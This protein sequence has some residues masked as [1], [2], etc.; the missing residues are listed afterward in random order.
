VEVRIG[1]SRT[2]RECRTEVRGIQ[3]DRWP[4]EVAVPADTQSLLASPELGAPILQMGDVI[5]EDELR[6]LARD[7]GAIPPMQMQAQA[8][9]PSGIWGS[10]IRNSRYNR[11]EAFS[12]GLNG[13]FR[14]GHY[15]VDGLARIGVADLE[16]NVELGISRR[17]RSYAVRL[18]GY[19]R[20]EAANPDTRPFGVI[21]SLSALLAQRDDGEYFRTMGGELTM[22]P[23]AGNAWKVR[24]F[25]EQQRPAEVE[26]QASLPHLFDEDQVFRPNIVADTADQGGMA[27]DL[28]LNRPLG[29]TGSIGADVQ[30]VG[31]AGTFDFWKGA[32]TLRAN[33]AAGPLAVALEGA[34]GT[35]TGGLPVQSLFYVGGPG[36]LRGYDGGAMTGESYWRGRA[37]LGTREPSVRFVVFSDVAW[38]GDRTSFTTGKPFLGVGGGVAFLDGLFRLDLARAMRGPTGWR[39]DFYV[40]GLF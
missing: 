18:G 38:A 27:L 22:A 14:S 29:G 6:E 30:T 13:V 35:S 4:V 34:A 11:V 12:T 40:D 3:D 32:L 7:I 24:L 9:L 23:D 28:K 21:N 37:E 33:S 17:A 15:E 36:T 19:R 1:G 39:F 2:W 31:E 20:L 10:L 8:L 25:W 5:S 26:T 16:P